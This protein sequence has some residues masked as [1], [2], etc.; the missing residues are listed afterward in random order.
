[1]LAAVLLTQYMSILYWHRE[2]WGDGITTVLIILNGLVL[3]YI[4]TSP[5]SVLEPSSL[6]PKEEASTGTSHFETNLG[7]C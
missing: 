5:P 4:V 7:C 1:M 2:D 3:L 6:V